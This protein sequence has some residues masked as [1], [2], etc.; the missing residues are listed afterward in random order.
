MRIIFVAIDILVKFL[1][2]TW[3]SRDHLIVGTTFAHFPFGD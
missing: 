3:M 2:D 1:K